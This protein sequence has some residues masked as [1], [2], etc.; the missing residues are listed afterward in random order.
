MGEVIFAACRLLF[1]CNDALEAE[2][3]AIREGMS[4]V[5]QWSN[6]PAMVQLDS[7]EA[8]SSLS[9]ASLAKS[10]NGHLVD[11]IKSFLLEREF[12]PV[13]ITHS[14]NKVSHCL[15]NYARTARSTACWLQRAPPFIHDLV[16][17]DCNPVA[18]E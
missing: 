10:P 13:K 17:P 16:L 12:I 15:A 3:Q 2:I 9:N 11:E 1:F 6:L 18:M 7:M 14:Q 8:L 5:L 4:L